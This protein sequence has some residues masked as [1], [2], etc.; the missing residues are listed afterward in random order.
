MDN[1]IPA[2]RGPL[3]DAAAE[4]GTG[5]RTMRDQETGVTKHWIAGLLATC[6]L[7]A[8]PTFAED[9]P[10]FRGPGATSRSDTDLPVEWDASQNVAWTADLPGRGL[11]GPIVVDGRVIVTANSGGRGDRLHILAFDEGT[12]RKLWRRQFW[13]TGNLSCHPKMCMATPTPASDGQRIVAFYSTND[14]V[15]VDLDGNV[16]WVRGLTK[17]YPHASNSVGMSS[18]PV[19]AGGAAIVQL[20]TEG[21]SFVCALDMETGENLWRHPRPKKASWVSPVVLRAINQADDLVLIQSSN[22]LSLVEPRTGNALWTIERGFS[23]VP[24]AVV[25][26]DLAFV[27][28][29]GILALRFGAGEPEVLWDSKK[30][31]SSTPS[32]VIVDDRMYLLNTILVCADVKTGEPIWRLR[33]EGSF[34]STPVVAGGKLY[35]FSEEGIAYVIALGDKEGTILAR[36]R[37]TSPDDP[38]AESGETILCSPAVANG[39]L[40]VRSDAHLWKIAKPAGSDQK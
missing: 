18:S 16:Q 24:S 34:S 36:N 12:G 17:D 37:M 4:S 1:V 29:D 14:V 21:D 9:W 22:K 20:E 15:C 25:D 10:E 35:A 2:P 26:G 28:G 13:A 38:D 33:L 40:F 8:G 7:F 39:A 32:P 27:P 6:G 11:S 23:T 19:I 30:L 31:R 3:A 5:I